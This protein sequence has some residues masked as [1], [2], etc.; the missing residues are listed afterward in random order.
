MS[1]ERCKSKKS[2]LIRSSQV[3]F[4]LPLVLLFPSTL[5]VS[6]VQTHI[7]PSCMFYC[8]GV[9]MYNFL[10]RKTGKVV[11]TYLLHRV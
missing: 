2:C 11:F 5:R 6:T 10:I 1:S 4:G 7:F 9:L 8:R 3:N